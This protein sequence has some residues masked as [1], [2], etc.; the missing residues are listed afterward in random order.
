MQSFYK[1]ISR[2]E[3]KRKAMENLTYIA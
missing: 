2:R 3:A 1:Y